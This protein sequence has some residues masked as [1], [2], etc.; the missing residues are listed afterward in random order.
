MGEGVDHYCDKLLMNPTGEGRA[1]TSPVIPRTQAY[2]KSHTRGCHG[3][4]R[5]LCQP[6][7]T[8]S[9][10]DGV[11]A[12]DMGGAPLSDRDRQRRRGG[13]GPMLERGRNPST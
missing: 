1:H 5:H 13:H 4:G 2:V 7:M 12:W 11:S 8:G 3:E 6:N 9:L 10:R